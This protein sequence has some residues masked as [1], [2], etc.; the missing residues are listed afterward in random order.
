MG[1]FNLIGEVVGREWIGRDGVREDGT[2]I[3]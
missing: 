2:G 1:E 3:K